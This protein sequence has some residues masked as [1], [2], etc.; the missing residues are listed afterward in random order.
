[1]DNFNLQRLKIS[2][3]EYVSFSLSAVAFDHYYD[4]LQKKIDRTYKGRVLFDQLLSHGTK[5]SRFV[6]VYF[7]GKHFD[8]SSFKIEN[9]LS[10]NIRQQCTSFYASNPEILGRG[11]LSKPNQFLIRKGKLI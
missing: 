7:D 2:T 8:M 5:A 4:E 11:I 3:F 10:D 9:S 6:S 1:M